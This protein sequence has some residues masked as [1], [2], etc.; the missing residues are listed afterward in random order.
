MIQFAWQFLYFL[1]V[2][3][4]PADVE[5]WLRGLICK[6]LPS[7]IIRHNAVN[8][9]IVWALF[10]NSILASKEPLNGKHLDG[11][12]LLSKLYR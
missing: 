2:W 1:A 9:V 8:D 4:T 7:K 6:Q 12:Y 3:L 11:L 5:L 10:S